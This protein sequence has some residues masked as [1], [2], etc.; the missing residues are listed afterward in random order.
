MRRTGV[1]N[2]SSGAKLAKPCKQVP[3]GNPLGKRHMNRFVAGLRRR[4]SPVVPVQFEEGLADYGRGR[5]RL[6]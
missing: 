2:E 5:F 4:R 6:S 1:A 3:S